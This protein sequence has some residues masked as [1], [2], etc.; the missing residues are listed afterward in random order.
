[1][2]I[3]VLST[4]TEPYLLQWWLPHAAKKFDFGVILDFNWE[5]N[6]D[7]STY[8]LY[9]KFVPHWRYYKIKY[10]TV[11]TFL[12]DVILHKFEKDLLQEFPN[13]WIITLNPTEFL[14]GDL[15]ILDQYKES[16]RVLIPC[17]LMNDDPTLEYIEPDP[18]VPLLKQ[19]HHGVHYTNDFPHPSK[20]PTAQ[21]FEK[22]NPP[23]VIMNMR[24]MRS[25]H[26]YPVDYFAT[27]V[28]AIGR[29]FWDMNDM[30]DKL[31]IC[32]MN[33]TPYTEA[34]LQRKMNVQRRLTSTDHATRRGFH[35]IVDKD[36]LLARKRFY[37][38]L[39]TDLKPEIEK[40]E[41]FD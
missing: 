14:I 27:S 34:F 35:H 38:Q 4:D 30:T 17:H 28:F 9:E 13:S 41:K 3:V 32:H 10:Q 20:G 23:D 29:H 40:L 5:D 2:K 8:E 31:A 21:L 39:T 6:T 22:L 1:M 12:W 36:K 24:W 15:S 19:R 16:K 26:N 33:F 18:N 11:S 37:D 25:I 7:D